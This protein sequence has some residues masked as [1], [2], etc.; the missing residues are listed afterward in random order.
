MRKAGISWG[1]QIL[2]I[3]VVYMLNPNAILEQI[4]IL[5]LASITSIGPSIWFSTQGRVKIIGVIFEGLYIYSIAFL[6]NVIQYNI[7]I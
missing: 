4:G 2:I 7:V 6:F 5:I 1:V 3:L